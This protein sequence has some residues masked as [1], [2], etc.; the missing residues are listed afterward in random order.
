[1]LITAAG[2]SDKFPLAGGWVTPT[3]VTT[4]L[5]GLSPD[6]VHPRQLFIP[7]NARPG[8]RPTTVVWFTGSPEHRGTTASPSIMN[9]TTQISVG[10]PVTDVIPNAATFPHNLY[11]QHWPGNAASGQGWPNVNLGLDAF[12]QLLLPDVAKYGDMNKIVGMGFSGG[13]VTL[14]R[15]LAKYPWLFAGCVFLDAAF[16]YTF[17]VDQ[18]HE[19]MNPDGSGIERY[20]NV[21][22]DA[23]GYTWMAQ[24]CGH[25]PVISCSSSELASIT[26]VPNDGLFAAYAAAGHTVTTLNPAYASIP[27]TFSSSLKTIRMDFGAAS[28]SEIGAYVPQ[29]TNTSLWNWIAARRRGE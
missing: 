24:N 9:N 12:P 6:T 23:Q 13:G 26:T 22:S 20:A 3:S 25:V 15:L 17:I 29:L 16:T 28:H 10:L 18:A 7:A 19:G 11:C 1:M 14:R 4:P 21:S 8:K 27:P 2:R 5:A